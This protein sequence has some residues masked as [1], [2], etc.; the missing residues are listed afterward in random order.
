MR[1][2]HHPILG[3]LDRRDLHITFNG[4]SY[5]AKEGETVAA[6]LMANGIRQL[7]K[8]RKMNK[9]KGVF[10]ANGR[11]CSCYVTING[12]EHMLACQTEVADGM[13][14]LPAIQDPDVRRITDG[15]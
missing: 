3:E 13:E 10:C 2:Q 15:D 4:K 14:I 5:K 9:S 6:A 11:C 7:G 8:S 12:E 1:I